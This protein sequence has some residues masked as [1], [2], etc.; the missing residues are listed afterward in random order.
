MLLRP[1]QIWPLI[2]LTVTFAARPLR[3]VALFFSGQLFPGTVDYF[4]V[5][6]LAIDQQDLELLVIAL[7]EKYVAAHRKVVAHLGRRQCKR[8]HLFISLL[9]GPALSPPRSANQSLTAPN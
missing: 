8:T 3:M 6:G 4:G 1:L 9:V 7:R 2:D 5:A